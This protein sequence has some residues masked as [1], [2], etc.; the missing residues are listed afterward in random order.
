MNY[1]ALPGMEEA[2]RLVQEKK[3][4]KEVDK[5]LLRRA[6]VG[7]T[8]MVTVSGMNLVRM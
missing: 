2:L 4:S 3:M 7:R 5:K 6:S 8:P 1:E